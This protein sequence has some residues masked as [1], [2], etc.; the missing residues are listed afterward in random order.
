MFFPECLSSSSQTILG[1]DEDLRNRLLM[2]FLL[3][4][5][6]S[7]ILDGLI[8]EILAELCL[9]E[10]LRVIVSVKTLRPFTNNGVGM[11]VSVDIMLIM[12]P[13]SSCG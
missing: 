1:G 2:A 8:F 7:S 10:I 9:K 5:R 11:L 3:I 6:P 4:P 12:F 13:L